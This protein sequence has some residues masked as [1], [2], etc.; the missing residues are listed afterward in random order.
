M[1]TL[2]GLWKWL[3][4]LITQ[5]G[6][7]AAHGQVKGTIYFAT[8]LQQHK[9]MLPHTQF[10]LWGPVPLCKWHIHMCW[11]LIEGLYSGMCTVLEK[12]RGR[13]V[14]GAVSC[15]RVILIFDGVTPLVGLPEVVSFLM[16]LPTTCHYTF[17]VITDLY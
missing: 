3:L 9:A 14:G 10:C 13:G 1:V 2:L 6:G 16:I 11:V 12:C 8:E 5:G 15:I 17:E 4:L 7:Y